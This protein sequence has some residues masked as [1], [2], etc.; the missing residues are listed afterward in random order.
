MHSSRS[1][2]R[3]RFSALVL[4]RPHREGF[5]PRRAYEAGYPRAEGWSGVEAAAFLVHLDLVEARVHHSG[6][7]CQRERDLCRHCGQPISVRELVYRGWSWTNALRH[8]IETHRVRP[9]DAFIEF[10]EA[11]AAELRDL[12]RDAPVAR[13]A[14]SLAR[15][16]LA[17]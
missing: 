7:L 11:A 15:P 8:Y 2:G 3:S 5:Y 17:G 1:P 9:G 6:K 10:I 13:A 14:P 12:W 4:Q 16:P